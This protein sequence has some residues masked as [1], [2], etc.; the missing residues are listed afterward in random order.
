MDFGNSEGCKEV[1]T[2]TQI[3]N[4]NNA[5]PAAPAGY[6]NILWQA[7]P[8]PLD[9][10]VARDVSAYIP[11]I[12]GVNVVPVGST[13]TVQASDNGKLLSF[14]NA[15]AVAVTIPEATLPPT[16]WCAFANLGVGT[17]TL[18]PSTG[19]LDGNANLALVTGSG[20]FVYS[21]NGTG[22]YTVRGA[23]P[24]PARVK[25]A[26]TIL[27]SPTATITFSGI[28]Q[29]YRNLIVSISA[30]SDV[31]GTNVVDGYMQFNG[32]MGN[33][34]SRHYL[35]GNN[36]AASAG[37]QAATA[38]AGAF[39]LPEATAS[40]GVG[41]ATI[42]VYNYATTTFLKGALT[43]NIF[44]SAFSAGGM[45]IA[46]AAFFWNNTA[47]ITSILFGLALAGNFTT[48][49]VFTLYGES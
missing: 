20:C 32:D 33:S 30:A 13:Y 47:A 18:T 25:L 6:Q 17:V 34:Y 44:A 1:R 28:S 27:A 22:L 21:N 9:P 37:S 31:V 12:A 5:E 29:T 45:F 11:Q 15:T 26:E 35:L 19:T 3:L 16:F 8:V 41:G 14:N 46:T 38:Q 7:D 49:S 39:T 48:G 2:P 40:S 36:N 42:T 43:Q 4:L 10:S 24:T 23:P